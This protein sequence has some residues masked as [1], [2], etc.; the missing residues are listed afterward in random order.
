MSLEKSEAYRIPE[1]SPLQFAKGGFLKRV[2][3]LARLEAGEEATVMAFL[4]KILAS[5]ALDLHKDTLFAAIRP[6]EDVTLAALLRDKQPHAV[7]SF[8][9]APFELGLQIELPEYQPVKFLG[10]IFLWAPTLATLEPNRTLK[11]RLWS[12]LKTTFLS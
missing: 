5:V 1:K 10:A 6:N 3:V 11:T 7:L 8:G 9:I 2:V 12:A 4:E